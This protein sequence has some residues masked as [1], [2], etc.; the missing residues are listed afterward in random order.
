MNGRV[1]FLFSSMLNTYSELAKHTALARPVYEPGKPIEVVAR[2]CDLDPDLILKMASNEN[3][4]GATP[5]GMKAALAM[6]DSVNLYPENSSRFLREAL[7]LKRGV[8]PDELVIGHGSSEIINLLAE[9]YI[10]SETEVVVGEYAFFSYKLATLANGGRCIEVAMP[11]FQHNLKAIAEAVTSATRLIFLPSPNNPTGTANSESELVELVESLPEHVILCFD[12]A[13]AEYLDDPPD[14]RALIKAGR[15]VI[16][17]RTFSKIYG[18]AG[19]RI[20]YGYCHRDLAEILNRVRF[21]FNVNSIAQ[22]AALGALKDDSFVERSRAINHAGRVQLEEGLDCLGVEWVPSKA[23]FLLVRVENS[24]RVV[25]F[26]QTNGIIVR[27]LN[28]YSLSDYLR[29]TV[30]TKGQNNRLLETLEECIGG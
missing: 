22:A 29:I 19:M 2:E 6:L 9:T 7:A 27:P 18:L 28:G 16:C 3:P 15:K 25:D 23:N 14:L 8:S 4:L 26:L 13:Y 12:E 17:L 10:N 24:K 11:N 21:A 1:S 20:G 5:L 30:G